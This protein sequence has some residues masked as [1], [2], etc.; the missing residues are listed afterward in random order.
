MK[1]CA[2][3]ECSTKGYARA[4]ASCRRSIR[5]TKTPGHDSSALRTSRIVK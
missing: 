4:M 3:R 5:L 2:D 1:S